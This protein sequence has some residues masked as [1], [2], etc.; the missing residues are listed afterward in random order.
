MKLHYLL[1]G[2]SLK[3][4]ADRC[5]GCGICAEVCPHGVLALASVPPVMITDRASCMECGAC[6]VNCPF[7]AIEVNRGVGC[8]AA[9]INGM[10]KGTAPSCD[11]G[12]SKNKCC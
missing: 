2:M 9:I 1:N 11:C 10:L 3:I 7:G 8:A 4:H 12:G 6:A 5:T